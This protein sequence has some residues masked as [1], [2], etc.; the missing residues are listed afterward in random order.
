MGIKMDGIRIAVNE[1]MQSTSHPTIYAIGDCIRGAMLAHKAEEEGIAVAET[2]AGKSGHVNYDA[3][4]GVIYTFPEVAVVGKTE[5]ELKEAK[6]DY[7]KG[8]FPFMANSRAR[9]NND[10]EGFV[11]I[12]ADKKTDRLLGAHII[13]PVLWLCELYFFYFFIF[14]FFVTQHKKQNKTKH[15]IFLHT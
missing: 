4:P 13:G 8:E 1:H 10:S 2:L 14:V 3:I 6:I 9:A 12:L 11:K 15:T 7:K 5:E